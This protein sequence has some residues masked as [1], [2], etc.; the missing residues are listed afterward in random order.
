MNARKRK[1][2]IY[3]QSSAHE[4]DSYLSITQQGGTSGGLNY[5]LYYKGYELRSYYV[6]CQ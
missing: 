2:K 1:F 5:I 6:L 4:M 3:V